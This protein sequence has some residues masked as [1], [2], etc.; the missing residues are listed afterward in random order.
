M[1]DE[2]GDR[3]RGSQTAHIGKQ[4]L[5]NLG[6]IEAGVVS[7]TS[8][9]SDEQVYW[10]VAVEPYTPAHHFPPGKDDDAFRTK[11]QI[12]LE[13]VTQAVK[14]GIPFRAVVA[15]NFYGEHRAFKAGLREA[16]IASVLA[17][18]PSHGWW[19]PAAEVGALWEAAEQAAWESADKPGDWQAVARQFRDGH[20]EPWW[21]V[22]VVAGPYGPERD[23]RVVV[24]TTDPTTLPELTTWYLATTL[25][26][27]DLVE[28][29]R[30]YGLRNWIEQSYKQVRHA[31]G[32]SQYQV[33]SDLAMRRH[34]TLVCRAFS[35]GWALAAGTEDAADA[36]S[37]GSPATVN[38]TPPPD[39]VAASATGRGKMEPNQPTWPQALR[40]VRAWLTLWY[41]LQRWWRAWSALPPPPGLQALLDALAHGYPLRAYDS[42]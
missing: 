26:D 41:W 36:P 12:A 8:L 39:P 27:A 4:Y 16:G 29:V 13:L 9:W 2:H 28:I 30:L 3:K 32:W 14:Q 34:W 19:H 6:K 21:A 1:I 23:Q 37:P 22:E 5:A 17:L 10:P 35:A 42:S 31:L 25:A 40:Q 7:V 15:D 38:D 24:A 20:T 33:R 18:K 11:P